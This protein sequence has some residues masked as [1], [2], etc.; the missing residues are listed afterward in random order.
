[1]SNDELVRIIKDAGCRVRL[2]NREILSDDSAATFDTSKAGPIICVATKYKSNKEIRKLLLHEFGHF[3]QWQAGFTDLVE[4]IC[5]G[6]EIVDKWLRGAHVESDLLDSAM[7]AVVLLEYDAEMR[8]LDIAKELGIRVSKKKAWD[9]A[10]SYIT[11]IKWCI[12]NRQWQPYDK[13]H[14]HY[15]RLTPKQVTAKLT[16]KEI[17]KL[18]K[19]G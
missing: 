16:N 14:M 10:H 2:F 7:V 19:P 4:N 9:H 3:K 13:L 18:K 15:D 12:V 11:A 5:N 1:M 6:W 17:K 8:S